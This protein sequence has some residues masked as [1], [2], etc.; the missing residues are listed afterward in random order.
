RS[1]HHAKNRSTARRYESR[2]F[3]FRMLVAKNS[4]K[5]FVVRSPSRV[6]MFGRVSAL[7][8]SGFAGRSSFIEPS[9]TTAA[10]KHKGRYVSQKEKGRAGLLSLCTLFQKHCHLI[11]QRLKARVLSKPNE[12][13]IHPSPSDRLLLAFQR[14]AQQRECVFSIAANGGKTCA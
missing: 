1:S 9:Y 4:R 14:R 2:V 10:V 5:R 8:R 11:Q 3:G 12:I 6:T 13:R 7:A